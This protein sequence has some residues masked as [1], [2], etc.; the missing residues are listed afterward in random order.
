M[1]RSRLLP[2]LVVAL[3]LA[4][5]T[6]PASRQPTPSAAR[7]Q[8]SDPAR[9]ALQPAEIGSIPNLTRLGDLYFA[10][11]PSPGD[12]ALLPD[13]GV[14]TVISLRH[15]AELGGFDEKAAVQD[16]GLQY[17]E[18]PWNGPAEL[19][20]DV[21]DRTR[22]MLLEVDSP[23]LFHCGSANRVGAVWLPY[24]VLDEGVDVEQA[25]EEARHIGMRTPEYE[26]RALDYIARNL[27]SR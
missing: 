2:A 7:V 1:I 20:D 27:E 24:R 16:L 6:E 14:T 5:C 23:T 8:S 11:Q 25:V 21:F 13:A 22:A 26:A 18:V 4:G 9:E 3:V 17:L 12:L 10:G 19:T 15:G